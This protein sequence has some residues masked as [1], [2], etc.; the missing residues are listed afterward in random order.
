[1]CLC[2]DSITLAISSAKLTVSGNSHICFYSLK[3][4][5]T[6]AWFP[7]FFLWVFYN[8]TSQNLKYTKPMMQARHQGYFWAGKVRSTLS[9]YTQ[10]HVSFGLHHEVRRSLWQSFIVPWIALAGACKFRELAMFS[11]EAP[12]LGNQEPRAVGVLGTVWYLDMAQ[13]SCI[14]SQICLESCPKSSNSSQILCLPTSFCTAEVE[15]L[16]LTTYILSCTRDWQ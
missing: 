6:I 15:M 11:H 2:A 1:M 12:S 16:L 8:S 14:S 10:T 3:T 5:V 13:E 4:S 9:S 7:G